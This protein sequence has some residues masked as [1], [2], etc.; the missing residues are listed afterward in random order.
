[1]CASEM[2]PP[3][4]R[5]PNFSFQKFQ[6]ENAKA[7]KREAKKEQRSEHPDDAPDAVDDGLELTIAEAL[8]AVAPIERPAERD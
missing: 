7:A 1:M 3:M 2:G 5:K 8:D 6:R 4:A